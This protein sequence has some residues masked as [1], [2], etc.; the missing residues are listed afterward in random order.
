MKKIPLVVSFY[1]FDYEYLPSSRPVWVK[2]YQRLF[3]E[4]SLFLAEGT[5]GRNKLIQIGCPADKVKVVHLGVQ[6]AD[7]PYFKRKKKRCEL[8]LV[9]IA[10]FSEKKGYDVTIK[11]F[12]KAF[13][14]CP[15][16]TLT[17]VGK[18]PEGMRGALQRMVNDADLERQVNF[19]DGIDFSQ[20]YPFLTK[21]QVFIHPSKY[22]ENGDC[23][24]GAPVVLLDA[25]ASGMPV[26]S[27]F[28]CDIPEEVMNGVSGI[29][30]D[31]NDV[32]E[33]A[34]AIEIFYTM[35][36]PVYRTYCENARKHVEQNYEAVK[37]AEELKKVYE[38]LLE[39]KMIRGRG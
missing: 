2:R 4:A 8:R 31:E 24:G 3:K 11:A 21:H 29:L 7:I 5:A 23:E 18:D 30:V 26:L 27:T 16:M 34:R 20:L 33:L 9:Q 39:G 28:H 19:I 10:S 1:G 14:R 35:E 15:N 13:P 17:L 6:V 32:D 37:C 38:N 12:I 22:G 36:E 25:Q